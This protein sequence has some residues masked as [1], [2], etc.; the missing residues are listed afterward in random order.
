MPRR[1][2]TADSITDDDLDA[3]YRNANVAWRRGDRW[4]ERATAAETALARL[5]AY[6]DELDATARSLVKNPEVEHPVA[7]N[8]RAKI[9]A[10]EENSTP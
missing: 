2:H 7:A 6:C 3:L 9:A 5:T 10:P 4:K 8:I 1:R